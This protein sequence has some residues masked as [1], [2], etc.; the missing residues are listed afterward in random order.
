MRTK[1]VLAIYQV[2]NTVSYE[3]G[4][5]ESDPMSASVLEKP[6]TRTEDRPLEA[7]IAKVERVSKESL[8]TVVATRSL[9]AISTCIENADDD[10]L[11]EIASARTNYDVLFIQLSKF[12]NVLILDDPLAAARLRGLKM[13]EELLNKAGG[14]LTAEQ[15]A[16]LLHMTRQGVDK[17][18]KARKLIAIDVGKRGYVY[19]AFQF[20]ENVRLHLEKVLSEVDSRIEGWTLLAFFI[21]GTDYLD[22]ASPLEELRAGN[23]ESVLRAARA[24]GKHG[25]P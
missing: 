13:K 10:E 6:K 24:Y 9:D 4:K 11:Q 2:W 17:R 18:R 23:L 12:L 1:I 8:Q 25:A 5:H 7:A 3:L 20:D 14:A 16:E 21:N 22:G 19:P 15:A